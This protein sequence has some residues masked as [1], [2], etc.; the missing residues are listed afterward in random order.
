M[1][2]KA[3]HAASIGRYSPRTHIVP[4]ME[5]GSSIACSDCPRDPGGMRDF[6]SPDWLR[7]FAFAA[8]SGATVMA[9]RERHREFEA[10]AY[11]MLELWDQAHDGSQRERV[12]G[13]KAGY[14][15]PHN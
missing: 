9:E 5:D 8:D 12:F 11:Q 14:T 6:E 2:A 1:F 4:E 13:A 10:E 3:D 15:R 7:H